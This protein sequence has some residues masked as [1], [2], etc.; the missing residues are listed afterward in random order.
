MFPSMGRGRN[1]TD[2]RKIKSVIQKPIAVMAGERDFKAGVPFNRNPMQYG[3]NVF[4]SGLWEK[5]WKMAEA[6]SRK[7][8][9]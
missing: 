7:P 8:T 4:L 6:E 5:G 2:K 3:P 9:K 1:L